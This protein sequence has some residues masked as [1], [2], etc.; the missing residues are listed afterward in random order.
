[1]CRF[2]ADFAN[3]VKSHSS[4]LKRRS[5]SWTDLKQ[6]RLISFTDKQV[7]N[8]TK[9][10]FYGQSREHQMYQKDY[11]CMKYFRIKNISFL[12]SLSKS[13]FGNNWSLNLKVIT[14]TSNSAPASLNYLIITER[15]PST[16]SVFQLCSHTSCTRRPSWGWQPL[17]RALTWNPQINWSLRTGISNSNLSRATFGRKKSPRAAVW[18]NK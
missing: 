11:F 4:H 18:K 6:K 14:L 2:M 3:E 7:I 12:L 5:F 17:H 9:S 16:R 1:M 10:R 13:F 8:L 15:E